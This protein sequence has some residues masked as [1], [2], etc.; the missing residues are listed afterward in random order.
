MNQAGLPNPPNLPAIWPGGPEHQRLLRALTEYHA[1]QP[2]ALAFLVFGSVARGEW[3]AYSDLDLDVVIADD[4]DV[5]PEA[6]IS[7]LCAAIGERPVLIAPRRGD[8]GDVVLESLAEFSIRYHPL[9]AT[10]PNII[11]S[12]RLLW[13]RIDV[14]RIRAAGLANAR[15]DSQTMET[16]V[17]RCVRAALGGATNLARGRRW[18]A[19]AA[20][21]EARELLMTLFT[22]A[23]GGER[24]MQSFE[25]TADAQLQAEL[26][27][28]TATWEPASIRDALLAACDLLTDQLA[29]FS[30]GRAQLTDDERA[31]LAHIRA[32]LL[33]HSVGTL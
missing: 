1:R 16:L 21:E 24:P 10:S 26:A 5:A 14:E 2:W 31:A 19:L 23:H 8:D 22:L 15:P 13:G 33:G 3:D 6:E 25:R 11:A 7:R 30:G 32:R 9:A 20:L 18:T 27:G 29:A 4:A 17:A 12:M 28:A